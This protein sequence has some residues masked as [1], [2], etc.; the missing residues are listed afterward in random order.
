LSD[1]VLPQTLDTRVP[2]GTDAG[3]TS[4][5]A[6]EFLDYRVLGDWSDD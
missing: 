3:R 4:V 5:A 1:P 2:L 6:P